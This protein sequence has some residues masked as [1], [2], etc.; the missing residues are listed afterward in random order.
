MIK[1]CHCE[2]FIEVSDIDGDP[3]TAI[4][5]YQQPTK[6]LTEYYFHTACFLEVSGGEFAPRDIYETKP[7]TPE[8]QAKEDEEWRKILHKHRWDLYKEG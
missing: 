8:E 4:E 3:Y 7:M 1:C 2:K 5:H 6:Q